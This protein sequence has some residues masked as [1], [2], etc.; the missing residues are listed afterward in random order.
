MRARRL[1]VSSVAACAV[2]VSFTTVSCSATAN[3]VNPKS[4]AGAG[5]GTV[6]A[7]SSQG[8]G[9]GSPSG[10]VGPASPWPSSSTA[11]SA[12]GSTSGWPSSVPGS[13]PSGSSGASGPSGPS[14]G[15]P[16]SSAPSWPGPSPRP[17]TSPPGVAHGTLTVTPAQSGM[18]FHVAV[19]TSVIAAQFPYPSAPVSTDPAVLAPG[20]SPMV[21]VCRPGSSC[22]EPP[23]DVRGAEPG[24]GGD[25]DFAGDVRDDREVRD[26][27]GG[28]GAGRF[29]G[30]DRRGVR[31][32][33]LA[34]AEGL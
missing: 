34:G 12:S 3:Q 25:H 28:D 22:T 6:S 11:G 21:I 18:T 23:A 17:P 20:V 19:G 31:G 26:A 1:S 15:W 4:T 24:D 8:S 13:G 29:R 10:P 33:R 32:R 30:H 7:S 5:T 16:S 9:T 2:L 27:H 14:R